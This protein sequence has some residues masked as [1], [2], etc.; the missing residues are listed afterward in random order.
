MTTVK[1][2]QRMR[3]EM[4]HRLDSGALS[5][6]GRRPNDAEQAQFRIEMR[7]FKAAKNDSRELSR[8][9]DKSLPKTL[10][11]LSK[12]VRSETAKETANNR[13]V[14]RLGRGQ[15]FAEPSLRQQALRL[16]N[17]KKHRL[18]LVERVIV[19]AHPN[20]LRCARAATTQGMQPVLND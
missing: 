3:R 7:A 4:Q 1:L 14:A 8:E 12:F 2:F 18:E 17:E 20:F 13:G 5:N 10:I 19:G 9:W 6:R 11:H 16:N 15:E